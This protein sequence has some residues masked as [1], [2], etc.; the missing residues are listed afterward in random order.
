MTDPEVT[1]QL[2]SK[3]AMMSVHVLDMLGH[4]RQVSY[5]LR[6]K[7]HDTELTLQMTKIASQNQESLTLE[8]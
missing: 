1:K 5:D 3:V 2:S 6:H 8:V 7:L 4:Q